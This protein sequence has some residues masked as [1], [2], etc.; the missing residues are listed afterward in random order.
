MKSIL[1]MPIESKLPMHGNQY[2]INRGLFNQIGQNLRIAHRI[3]RDFNRAYFKGFSI[4]TLMSL[5]D[6]QRYL[7]P[8]FLVFHSPSPSILMP[9]LSIN[10]CR[11]PMLSCTE[12]TTLRCFFVG[13]LCWNQALSKLHWR[14]EASFLPSLLF[15][16]V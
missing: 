7:V 8:C 16:V 6:Y 9:V 2:C 14:A 12:M 13:R 3:A 11:P 1:F 5:A 10:H 4:N 15:G